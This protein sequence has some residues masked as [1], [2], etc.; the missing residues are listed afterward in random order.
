MSE[1]YNLVTNNLNEGS[2]GRPVYICAS[3]KRS[4]LLLKIVDLHGVKIK[5]LI[6]L[7]VTNF[8]C[9]MIENKQ[10]LRIILKK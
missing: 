10:L 4:S 3:N 8:G 5:K 7:E 2:G 9:L 6:S 1:N